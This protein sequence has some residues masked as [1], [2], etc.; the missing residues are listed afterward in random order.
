MKLNN[1]LLIVKT[2]QGKNNYSNIKTATRETPDE[3]YDSFRVIQP[4]TRYWTK[5]EFS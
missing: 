2:K 1:L 3:S 4:T 5:R